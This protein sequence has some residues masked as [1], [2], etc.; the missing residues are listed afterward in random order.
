M[1]CRLNYDMIQR[2]ERNMKEE[3][4]SKATIEKYC[5]DVKG[6]IRHVGEGT[7]VT[8]AAVIAYKDYLGENYELTSANSMLAAVNYFLRF[9]GRKNCIVKAFKIQKEAFRSQDRELTKEEYGR[10]LEAALGNGNQRLYLI[11]LTICATGIRISELPFITVSSLHSHRTRVCLKGKTRTV[12]LP[13]EL[14][15]KLKDYCK[16]KG[17]TSGSVFVTRSGKPMD[18]SNIFHEAMQEGGSGGD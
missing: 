2:L 3:E 8:K 13:Q 14:C 15:G 5:R 18:R 17:I 4:K 12:L 11:M 7:C 9:L 1:A 6:F 16:R 10:L